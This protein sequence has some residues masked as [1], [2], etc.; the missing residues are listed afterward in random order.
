MIAESIVMVFPSPC[1]VCFYVFI[2]Q[3]VTNRK[4][5]LSEQAVGDCNQWVSALAIQYVGIKPP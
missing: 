1:D 4:T 5:Q 2:L 3:A